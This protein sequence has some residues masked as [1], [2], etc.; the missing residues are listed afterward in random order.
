MTWS[1]IGLGVAVVLAL[2]A[3][4]EVQQGVLEPIPPLAGLRYVNLVNDT[5]AVDFRII[6]YVGEAPSAGAANF[7]TGGQPYGVA[8]NFLPPHWPVEAGRDVHIRVFMN[9]T[10]PAIASQVVFDTTCTFTEGTNYTFYLYGSARGAGVHAL[11][12]TDAVP[13]I[14]GS[15]IAVRAIHLGST[16]A[17]SLATANVDVDVVAQATPSPLTGTSQFAN[18][19]YKAVS[20]YVT[21]P[22]S[23][24]LKAVGSAPG[25]RTFT[26]FTA[27]LPP[28]TVG[29]STVNPIAGSNVAGTAISVVVVPPS[30]TGSAAPQTAAFLVPT[31]LFLIDRQPALTAP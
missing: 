23:A 3:C 17:P 2:G 30:V 16:L 31:I 21:M 9:G 20:N 27:N 11:V 29:T 18:L 5:S 14:T 22:G 24:T 13:A 6:N 10:T 4:R 19:A 8:T 1:R 28:G 15:N 25:S 26:T 12:T 7:R